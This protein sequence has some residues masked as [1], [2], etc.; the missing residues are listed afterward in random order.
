MSAEKE[1]INYWLNLQN[2]F[3]ISNI[4][5]KNKDIG[6]L[7]LKLDNEKI[8]E[9]LHIEI[10][11]SISGNTETSDLQLI[12]KFVDAKFFD[13]AIR[14]K[15]G[16]YKLESLKNLLVLGSMPKSRKKEIIA[17]Y[18][19]KEIDIIEFEDIISSVM[20]NMDTQY[21]KNDVIRTL[22]LVKYLLLPDPIKLVS[23]ISNK[24]ILKTAS[25]SQ[26][27]NELLKQELIKK[28]FTKTD[29]KHIISMLKHSTIKPEK[30]AEL[31]ETDILNRR[32]RKPFLTSLLEQEKI[33]KIHIKTTKKKEE[34]PLSYFLK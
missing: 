17:K 4:K 13:A 3:T 22:Q 26:F 29:E 28:G 34:K 18:K 14:K 11:C 7:A 6:I 21:Y 5:V 15:I 2:F 12:N 24:K 30:L 9:A 31:L 19:K 10:S 23:L 8:K 33:R 27:L 1:I 16:K 32:T 20:L 25:Q